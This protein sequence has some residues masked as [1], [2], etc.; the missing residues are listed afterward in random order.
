M[1]MTRVEEVGEALPVPAQASS[2]TWKTGEYIL[3]FG[4]SG[5][6]NYYHE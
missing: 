5:A 3:S 1:S 2:T 6:R 4:F